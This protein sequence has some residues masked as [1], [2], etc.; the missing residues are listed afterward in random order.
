MKTSDSLTKI[1]PALTKAL[2][3]IGNAT[4][5]S[6]NPHFK[7]SYASLLSVI[8]ATK[9]TLAA[10]GLAVIQAPGWVEGRVSVTSR[11]IHTSGEW[12]E[13]TAEAPVGKAD[14][15]GV[16][17]ATT[18][19]RRYSLAALCGITQADDDGNAAA[20]GTPEPSRGARPTEHKQEVVA[21]SQKQIGFIHSMLKTVELEEGKA[22]QIRAR[23]SAGMTADEASKAIKWLQSQ[24]GAAE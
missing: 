1:A 8:E 16:G 24:S 17:S 23:I 5:D 7:S 21:A 14:P 9:D 4:K 18:Y 15:A 12:I 2:A 19:L 11:I 13:S 6:K 3:E 20:S 22:D 10:H